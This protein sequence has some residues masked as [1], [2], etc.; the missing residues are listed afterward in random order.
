M[1]VKTFLAAA[2]VVALGALSV[3][4][5]SAATV[6]V[7][8]FETGVVSPN[9]GG[10]TV[11]DGY[12]ASPTNIQSGQCETGVCTIESGQGILPSITRTDNVLFDL[13]RFWFSIQGIGN[14]GANYVKIDGFNALNVL[15]ASLTFT[16]GD[17][18]GTFAPQ[19]VPTPKPGYTVSYL[20]GEAPAT[21]SPQTIQKCEN[22]EICK[23]TGYE[24]FLGSEFAG[25]SKFTFSSDSTANARLDGITLSRDGGGVTPPVPLPAGL[26][27]LLSGMALAGVVARRKSRKA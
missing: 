27:L 24:V 12:T 25:L 26:P 18:L 19:L 15:Q 4:G 3:S 6:T 20:A 10:S 16:V 11:V 1:T 21:G 22:V 13:T 17:A 14:S 2:S 8:D 9:A 7:I 5:A 23:S